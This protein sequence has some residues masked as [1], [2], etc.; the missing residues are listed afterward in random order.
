VTLAKESFPP[1]LGE[2]LPVLDLV[3]LTGFSFGT[4][5]NCRD[6]AK[7]F[8]PPKTPADYCAAKRVARTASPENLVVAR[9]RQRHDKRR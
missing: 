9:R 8:R 2:A 7:Q 5:G 6:E 4:C 1:D 3:L